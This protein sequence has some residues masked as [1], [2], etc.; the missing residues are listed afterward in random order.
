M[1]SFVILQLVFVFLSGLLIGLTWGIM[2]RKPC[3]KI[4]IALRKKEVN[5][6]SGFRNIFSDKHVGGIV[7]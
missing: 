4:K 3:E 5:T 2:K 7:Q 6:L 1:M